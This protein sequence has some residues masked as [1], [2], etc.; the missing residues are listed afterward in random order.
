MAEIEERSF[1]AAL[2]WMTAKGGLW[3]GQESRRSRIVKGS[4]IVGAAEC[5]EP[6]SRMKTRTEVANRAG[7]ITQVKRF[8]RLARLRRRIS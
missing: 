8:A 1:V 5:G 7:R 4:S 3:R 2:L 6:L